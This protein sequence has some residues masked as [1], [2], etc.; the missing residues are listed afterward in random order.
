MEGAVQDRR[1]LLADQVCPRA[2]L[3]AL[4]RPLEGARFSSSRTWTLVDDSSA[5]RLAPGH[6][7]LALR[8]SAQAS[9]AHSAAP[10]PALLRPQLA[11]LSRVLRGPPGRLHDPPAQVPQLVTPRPLATSVS[12]RRRRRRRRRGRPREG[13]RRHLRDLRAL[14][15]ALPGRVPDDG[16][17]RRDRLGSFDQARPTATL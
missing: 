16:L 10:R 2:L 11:G 4:P 12:R 6:A 14:Q 3:C 7:R 13:P 9:R 1:T 17:V 8:P 5:C 15:P